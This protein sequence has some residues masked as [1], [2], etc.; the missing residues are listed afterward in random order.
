MREPDIDHTDE[1]DRRGGFIIVAVLWVL[2]A[3]A[4]LATIYAVYVIDTAVAFSVHDER[5]QADALFSA[6][7]ELTAAQLGSTPDAPSIGRFGFRLGDANVVVDFRTEN[8]RI[9]LNMAPKQVLAGLFAGLG[10]Q[11]GLAEVYADSVIAWRTPPDAATS[12]NSPTRDFRAAGTRYPARGAP[13]PHPAELA[14]VPGLPEMLVDRAMP[15]VTVYSGTP[16]INIMGAAPEVLAALPGMNPTL[17]HALLAQREAEPQNVQKLAALL[18][19][20]Q[21]LATAQG[22]K[23]V[24]VT[25][26]VAFDGGQ[27]MS[28]DIVI[29]LL[30]NGTEPYRVLSWRDSSDDPA[31]DERPRART[32]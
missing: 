16:Q 21:P 20:G 27:R 24:R 28:A 30:D 29:F 15:F 18:G 9:D 13:F 17:L 4:T 23:A 5:L 32:R 26:R 10:T 11:A 31:S 7:I 2:G 25:S 8:T 1:R 3:L 6:S 12:A 19:S 22:I 14:L